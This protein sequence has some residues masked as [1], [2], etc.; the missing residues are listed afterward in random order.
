MIKGAG[1]QKFYR[2]EVGRFKR[3]NLT[4]LHS[5]AQE[6]GVKKES[7]ADFL[8]RSPRPDLAP[9]TKRFQLTSVAND[10]CLAQWSATQIPAKCEADPCGYFR[11]IPRK[12][13]QLWLPERSGDY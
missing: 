8:L 4:D 13:E 9:N 1:K 12:N 3:R 11:T 10:S 6:E 7:W 5:R 2:R